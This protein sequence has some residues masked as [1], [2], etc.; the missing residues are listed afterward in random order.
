MKAEEKKF[1]VFGTGKS[2][3]AAAELLLRH[4]ADVVLYDSRADLDI[5][6]FKEK[7]TALAGISVVAGELPDEI[8][9]QVDIVILSPG[10]PCDLPVV[11]RLRDAGKI[12][13]GEVE[14]AW[15]M[16]R[17][18]VAAITGTNGKTTTTSLVGKILSEHYSDVKVVGNIGI[19]YTQ[20]ADETKEDTV[21]AA[22][23]SS[24]QLETIDT[25]APHVSAILNITPDHLDRHHTMENYIA[26]KESITKNQRQGCLK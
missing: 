24:F 20:V 17:G 3:V 4:E 5:E 14:L 22:E 2:G 21:I 8:A 12:I 1:L 15:Q 18:T 23:I 25:F 26:A 11:N 19:P 7:H 6:D 13:W 10:V 16:G 9:D